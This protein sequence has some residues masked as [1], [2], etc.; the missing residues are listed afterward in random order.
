MTGT[1]EKR[2]KLNNCRETHPIGKAC[3]RH[4]RSPSCRIKASWT[5]QFSLYRT[6]IWL[7]VARASGIVFSAC[8]LSSQ[9]CIGSFVSGLKS[10]SCSSFQFKQG[11]WQKR[12]QVRN[13]GCFQ[14][15]PVISSTRRNLIFC[16]PKNS[17]QR[18]HA[19]MYGHCYTIC[20][21]M[22]GK[23]TE[24]CP[25]TVDILNSWD[26]VHRHRSRA[27]LE[28]S[29]DLKQTALSYNLSKSWTAQF[30]KILASS[31]CL[32]L[33]LSLA[34]HRDSLRRNPNLSACYALHKLKAL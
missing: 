24:R 20:A 4:S 25:R 30:A 13:Y 21:E 15:F 6:K 26:A 16:L 19:H 11:R 23:I 31:F 33:L 22:K 14:R 28:A 3:R 1:K 7:P 32:Q 9:D 12:S 34:P 18:Y 27:R 2:T 8:I 17:F 5:V 29:T 10:T